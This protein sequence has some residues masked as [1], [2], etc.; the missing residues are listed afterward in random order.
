MKDKKNPVLLFSIKNSIPFQVSESRG[1]SRAKQ[2]M[3]ALQESKREEEKKDGKED[4]ERYE[5][6][7]SGKVDK[8]L[9]EDMR[10]W[11]ES[12]YQRIVRR[13]ERERKERMEL[14]SRILLP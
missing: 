6:L 11:V 4:Q 5:E 8:V 3:E 14:F 1:H 10:E 2:L 9:G 12:R 7:R 13:E